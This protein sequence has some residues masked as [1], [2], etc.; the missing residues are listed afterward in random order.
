MKFELNWRSEKL[1]YSQCVIRLNMSSENNDF[2]FQ[3][4]KNH[5]FKKNPI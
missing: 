5:L 4:S 2:G 3:Y 1:I